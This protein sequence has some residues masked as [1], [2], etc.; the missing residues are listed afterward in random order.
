MRLASSAASAVRSAAGAL[1]SPATNR[2][3]GDGPSVLYNTSGASPQ[4]RTS[5][6]SRSTSLRRRGT[7]AGSSSNSSPCRPSAATGT[8]PSTVRTF[9]LSAANLSAIASAIAIHRPDGGGWSGSLAW[10]TT[11][12]AWFSG[13]ALVN[14]TYCLKNGTSVLN[15]WSWSVDTSSRY[16]ARAAAAATPSRASPS[17]RLG[18]LMTPNTKPIR[19]WSKADVRR[20]AGI[21]GSGPVQPATRAASN[22][23]VSAPSTVTAPIRRCSSP[24][25]TSSPAAN[26]ANSLPSAGRNRLSG[27]SCS[28]AAAT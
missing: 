8:C 11:Y 10:T 9:F 20:E 24:A 18:W 21:P 27:L 2:C 14:D 22:S 25:A 4:R 7:S 3:S 6:S 16:H 5:S 15:S 17:V 28:T 19:R 13:K 12:P 23:R 26:I 1:D